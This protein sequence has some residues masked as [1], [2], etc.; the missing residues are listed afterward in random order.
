MNMINTANTD[1]NNLE[2][3]A[4]SF[5]EICN[6]TSKTYCIEAFSFTHQY[7]L[8]I[9]FDD[10]D[11]LMEMLKDTEIEFWLFTDTVNNIELEVKDFEDLKRTINFIEEESCTADEIDAFSSLVSG[12]FCTWDEVVDWYSDNF[13]C[14]YTNDYDFGRYLADELDCLNIPDAIQGYFNYEE[15]GSDSLTNDYAICNGKV[16]RNH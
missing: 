15:Y 5:Y 9:F 2:A 11:D 8:N 7:G 4:K 13:V 14:D 10:Y 6:D 3:Q 1:V 16:Y 12:S